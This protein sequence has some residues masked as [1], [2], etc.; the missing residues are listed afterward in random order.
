[1]FKKTK[2]KL[3]YLKEENKSK[4]LQITALLKENQELRY[5]LH[6]IEMEIER[7]NYRNDNPFSLMNNITGVIRNG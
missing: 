7:F 2:D 3:D 1:M 6:K 5:R 4:A